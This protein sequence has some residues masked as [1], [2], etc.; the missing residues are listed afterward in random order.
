MRVAPT[1]VLS[2]E[3][4]AARSPRPDAGANAAPSTHIPRRR[5]GW[6]A[7]ALSCALYAWLG[8]TAE[9]AWTLHTVV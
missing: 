3:E 4:S 7:L 6:Q 9:H 5:P 8:A 1:I 2:D